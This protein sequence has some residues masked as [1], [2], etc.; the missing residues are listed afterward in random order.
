MNTNVN[1]SNFERRTQTGDD[2]MAKTMYTARLAAAALICVLACQ[3]GT[4]DAGDKTEETKTHLEFRILA[5]VVDDAGAMD[6]AAKYLEAANRDDKREAELQ[7]FAEEGKPPA[8]GEKGSETRLGYEWVEASPHMLRNLWLTDEP[9]YDDF[10]ELD[11]DIREQIIKESDARKA[12]FAKAR[13]A[14]KAFRINPEADGYLVFSRPCRDANLSKE[15]REQKK[16]DCFLLTRLAKSGMEL[17]G[18]HLAKV[19]EGEDSGRH[20]AV[21]YDLDKGGGD[22]LYA[23]TANNLPGAKDNPLFK[24][25]MAVIVDGRILYAPDINSKIGEKGIISGSFSRKQVHE[26]A[27]ALRSDISKKR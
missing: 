15:E 24:R 20:P 23:L 25:K 8:A 2:L 12:Q 3:V 27:E 11:K 10:K 6:A 16:F 14:G 22:L 9:P 1:R 21:L 5:N 7:K 17:T 4:A 13:E 18:K 26:I 19:E